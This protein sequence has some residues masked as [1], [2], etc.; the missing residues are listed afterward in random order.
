MPARV[1]FLPGYRVVV[2]W[3]LLNGALRIR[4]LVDS[5]AAYTLLSE[6]VAQRVG[7]TLNQPHSMASIVTIEHV[8]APV[9]LGRIDSL[10]IGTARLPNVEVGLTL[11]SPALGVD[12]ILGLSFLRH[13]RVTFEFDRAT[14]VLRDLRPAT[15]S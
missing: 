9:R 11:L 14:L 4:L 8:V 2:V 12:G 6:E 7:L 5:G 10:Q 15:S 13:F 3:G 1:P